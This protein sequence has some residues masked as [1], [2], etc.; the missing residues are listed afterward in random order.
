MQIS[1]P[2]GART[3]E[4]PITIVDPQSMT[5]ADEEMIVAF[6]EHM[7]E[8]KFSA[9]DIGYLT[10][11]TSYHRS[12][13]RMMPRLW[14]VRF[15]IS[16]WQHELMALA[17]SHQGLMGIDHATALLQNR[18]MAEINYRKPMLYCHAFPHGLYPDT[19]AW[20]PERVLR[21]ITF[22]ETNQQ[23]QRILDEAKAPFVGYDDTHL[24][25]PYIYDLA[26]DKYSSGEA[27]GKPFSFEEDT[28]HTAALLG[29]EEVMFRPVDPY[30]IN[31]HKIVDPYHDIFKGK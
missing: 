23:W 1:L 26:P 17:H 16:M 14:Q 4:L 11:V 30:Y 22:R 18:G 6:A 29:M 21:K 13:A 8:S 3:P 31:N 20:M 9:G 24:M 10:E 28:V 7:P 25:V 27:L 2:N 12:R 19:A 5:M 15:I